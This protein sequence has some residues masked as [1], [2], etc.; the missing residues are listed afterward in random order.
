MKKRITVVALLIMLMTS[1]LVLTTRAT[2]SSLPDDELHDEFNEGWGYPPATVTATD[3]AGPGVRFDYTGLSGAGTAKCDGYPLSEKAGG[4]LNSGHYSDFSAYTHYSLIFK[5]VGTNYVTVN[6]FM[7]TGFTNGGANPE[8]DTYWECSWITV[9]A[10]ETK[11]VTLNFSKAIVS[12]A[13]DDP[14]YPHYANGTPD[15][16]I[17]RLNEVTKIGFQ[18]CGSGDGSVIVQ[19]S[20][21]LYFDPASV[22]KQ[23]TDVGYNFDVEMKIEEVTNLYGFDIKITWDEALITRSAAVYNTYL[24]AIWGSGQWDAYLT[25]SGPGYYWFVAVS[26]QNTF[27]NTGSQ[28]LLKLTFTV[29]DPLTNSLTGTPLHFDIHQLSDKDA[30]EITNVAE[31][32]AYSIL[33]KKPTLSMDPT[34]KTCRMYG[35]LFDISLVITDA[36]SVKDFQFEI[37]YNT[38]L[39]DFNQTTWNAW[40]SGTSTLDEGNGIITG[41]ANGD[42]MNGS[43]TLVTITFKAA[44][45]HIWK[46]IAGWVNDQTGTISFQ[47]ATLSYPSPQP[48]LTYT[49]GGLEQISVGPDVAYTFS[50]I[51]GD[52]DNNGR[53]TITDLRTIGLL[54]YQTNPTYN[55]VGADDTINLFDLV[56]VSSNMWYV[57]P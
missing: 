8:Y 7:N 32:G 9:N 54:W 26:T 4:A 18:V 25:T 37:H 48:S 10:G 31:D 53:V 3:I 22:E 14:V 44:Y 17:W 38:T 57:Y 12:N 21:R 40:G 24:D 36:A 51:K 41:S 50:P 16:A 49:R 45:Y 23:Y 43:L 33:G 28:S 29:K 15:I 55:L 56:I 19:Q 39:L 30:N 42:A 6:L 46:N 47:S 1:I 5:N 52:V 20:T 13:G 34:S 2:T 35:E 11:L 27:S